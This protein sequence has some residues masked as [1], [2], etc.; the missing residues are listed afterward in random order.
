MVTKTYQLGKSC[1]RKK[2]RAFVLDAKIYE[3]DFLLI[4]IYNANTEKEQ[5]SVFNELTAILSYFGNISDH[6][7][8]F[9]GDFDI[10][11]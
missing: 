5:I 2:R 1:P 10:Y 7:L 9:A 11:F 6:N 4:N 3:F 8:I